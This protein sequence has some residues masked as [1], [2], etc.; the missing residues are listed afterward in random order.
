MAQFG[1]AMKFSLR[2]VTSEDFDFDFAFAVKKQAMGAH[3][4]A[5][6][7][8][9]EEFQ[10]ELHKTR[11][12]EKPWY[13]INSNGQDVGTVSLHEI[14]G[15]ILRFGEFYILDRCRN[16]GLGTLVLS[17]LLEESDK[18]KQTV[19]LEFLKWNP[20]GSLYSRHG[21]NVISENEIHFFME[22]RPNS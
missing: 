13:V 9:D 3:I 16:R 4:I 1:V 2:S 14:E 18:K 10:L 7:G 11:W 8:W 17:T 5:K 6:W 20:V 21:F 12:E 19:I 22:R 15:D